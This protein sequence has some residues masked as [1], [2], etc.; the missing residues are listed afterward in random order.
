MA[1]SEGFEPS[2]RV[3]A[4]RFSRPPR[5]TAPATLRPRKY[6]S[7]QNRTTWPRRREKQCRTCQEHFERTQLIDRCRC[8]GWT[9]GEVVGREAAVLPEASGSRSGSRGLTGF[10]RSPVSPSAVPGAMEDGKSMVGVFVDPDTGVDV[11]VAVGRDLR[12]VPLVSRRVVVRASLVDAEMSSRVPAK[13]RG[14]PP[15]AGSAGP[16]GRPA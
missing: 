13:G 14:P 11:V 8:G 9:C 5:S 6:T 15:R 16:A 3:R 7:A 10:E 4:Q 2:V 12:A 1:E